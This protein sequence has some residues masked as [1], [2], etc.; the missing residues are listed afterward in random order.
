MS[1]RRPSRNS[2]A[3][4]AL[5]LLLAGCASL[6]ASPPEP[7]APPLTPEVH[8]LL[9]ALERRWRQF[10]DLRTRVEITLRHGD[11]TQ[12]LSG[13]LLLKS[14]DSLRLEAL[15]PWGQPF[16]VLAANGEVFTLYRVIENRAWVGPASAR[17]TERWLGL[18]L[19]PTDLVG[20]LS[21]HVPPMKELRTGTLGPGNGL[22]PSLELTAAGKTLRIWLDPE[23]LVIHQV[24][25]LAQDTSFRVTYE[26]GGAG[27]PPTGLT[28]TALD[29]PLVLSVRY[30]DLVVGGGVP[31]ELFSLTLPEHAKIRRFR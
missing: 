7:L 5:A 19:E 27:T 21:G 24:E 18:A 2:L 3:L 8:R 10:E 6:P 11:R 14:P 12:F 22:G 23:S 26:G 20:I 13:V 1:G 28:L 9:D 16:L 30:R 4:A 29:Q 17:A 15:S 31:P 25:W